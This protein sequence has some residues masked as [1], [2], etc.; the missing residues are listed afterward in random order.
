MPKRTPSERIEIPRFQLRVG[1]CLLGGRLLREVERQSF[2][3]ER[4]PKPTPE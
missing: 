4:D 2:G 3:A 1:L